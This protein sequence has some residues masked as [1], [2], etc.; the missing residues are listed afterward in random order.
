VSA[1]DEATDRR[2]RGA[3]LRVPFVA[4]CTLRF[5]DGRRGLGLTANLN[6]LG[7]YIAAEPLPQVGEVL[8]CRF[9]VPPHRSEICATGRVAWVNP[10]SP[11]VAGALPVGFGLQ[12]EPVGEDQQRA[13]EGVVRAY[14]SDTSA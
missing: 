13:L 4:R 5:A 10:R 9:A 1:P 6:E 14:L 3:T 8:E 12:F 7:A 11:R 2:A